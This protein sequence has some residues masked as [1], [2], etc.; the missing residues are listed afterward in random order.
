MKKTPLKQ[1]IDEMQELKKTKI[2]NNSLKAID[3][4]IDLAYAK[5]EK[6]Q[7]ES[8]Q[9]IA[10]DYAISFANWHLLTRFDSSGKY[11]NKTD[12]ELLEIFK[13]ERSETVA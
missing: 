4:C 6:E 2:F 9:K 8:Y 10:E 5:L 3:E 12:I 13:R 1:L 7:I 11:L